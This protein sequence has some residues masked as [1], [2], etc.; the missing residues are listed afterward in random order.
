M[1]NVECRMSNEEAAKTRDS[2]FDILHPTFDIQSL[3]WRGLSSRGTRERLH[4][5]REG[6]ARRGDRSGEQR[7]VSAI[8]GLNDECRMSNVE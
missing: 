3:V 2:S 1:K 7:A 8:E 5:Q 4:Q 6:G